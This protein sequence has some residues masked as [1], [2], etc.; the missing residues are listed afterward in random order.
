MNDF[1]DAE[2]HENSR[3]GGLKTLINP[4]TIAKFGDVPQVYI[5]RNTSRQ[6]PHEDLWKRSA[7]TVQHIPTVK[8]KE[9]RVTSY[10]DFT[11]T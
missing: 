11:K 8:R 9:F 3:G 10:E 5:I 1:K 4:G 6:I 2:G 7:L